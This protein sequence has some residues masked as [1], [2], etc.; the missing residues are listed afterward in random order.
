MS[1]S[2]ATPS[3]AYVSLLNHTAIVAQDEDKV[4]H[5]VADRFNFA[6]AWHSQLSR[7]IF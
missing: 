4:A 7:R 6:V 2:P 3:P 5:R 1:E